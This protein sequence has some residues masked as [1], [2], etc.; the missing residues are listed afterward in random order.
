MSR[1][2]A[3]F[4]AALPLWLVLVLVAGSVIGVSALVGS[5]L[6]AT[7][8]LTASVSVQVQNATVV[9]EL[10]AGW[11]MV[12]LPVEPS[13]PSANSVLDGV[14]YYQ[15]VTWSGSGYI[16]ATGFKWGQGYW[17]LV[18]QDINVSVTRKPLSAVKLP[19]KP[20]WNM[21]GGPNSTVAAVKVFEEYYQL[22]TWSGSGYLESSEFE[23]G[24]GYWALVL[25]ETDVSIG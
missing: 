19:L 16:E 22:V 5:G 9:L 11:N 2:R 10:D 1:V 14:E 25:V 13:D 3:F 18:L 7:N 23:P 6:L 17:L 24:M 8:I 15:L 21:V 12:S 20:G 4:G